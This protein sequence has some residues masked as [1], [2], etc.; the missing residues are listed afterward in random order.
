[1][2][3]GGDG[4]AACSVLSDFPRPGF[5]SR[6]CL[7]RT[8]TGWGMDRGGDQ[9]G[10]VRDPEKLGLS[11]EGGSCRTLSLSAGLSWGRGSRV[12]AENLGG[13]K[14]RQTGSHTLGMQQRG[15]LLL[16]GETG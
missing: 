5:N 3:G 10:R 4:L 15:P 11:L 2:A 9:V 1:M 13:P 7:G 8:Q 14:R 12:R 16:V 6:L